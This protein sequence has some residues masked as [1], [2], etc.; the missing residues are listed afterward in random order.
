MRL[1]IRWDKLYLEMHIHVKM[2]LRKMSKSGSKWDL[3][4]TGYCASFNFRR[5][6]RAVT[7]LYDLAL[8]DSGV[9]STQFTLLVGIAKNQPVAMGDLAH[10]LMI[11]PTTLTRSLR[12][13][14]KEGLIK[15]SGRSARRQRFLNLTQKGEQALKRSLPAWRKAHGQFVSAVGAKYWNDL[16]N[17]LETLAHLAG[18]LEK[19]K[20]GGSA[21]P[22]MHS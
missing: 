14:E 16:R 3:T 22:P 21:R 9:R 15:I 7:R 1:T 4:G 10:V 20:V 5:A 18:D 2:S 8:E 12:L 13:L 11:D 17:E 19:L 6:A